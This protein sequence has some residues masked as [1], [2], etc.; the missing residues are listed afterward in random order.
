MSPLVS[1]LLLTYNHKKYISQAIESVL[2]QK[3][4][5]EFEILIGDDCS[6]DGTCEIVDDYQK[7]HPDFIKTIRSGENVGALKNE[8]RL[9]EAAE[10]KYLA[11]LE[12]DDYWTDSLKLQ[13]QIEFLEANPDYGLVHGDVNHYYENTGKMEYAV[14][15][16]T[17]NKIP[18]GNIFNELIKPNP[19]FIKTATACF[20]KELF[21]KH[22]DYN[23]AISQNWPLTD[24]GIW[25]DIA[26]HSKVYYFD[27]VFATYRLLNESASRTSSPSKKLE[28]HQRLF[29]LKQHYLNKY[30]CDAHSKLELEIDYY[31]SLI[32]IAYNLN[33]QEISEQAENY[34][35]S[36][37]I[38]L[39]IKEKVLLLALKK[40]GIMKAIK[41]FKK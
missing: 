31:K 30:R 23:L 38:P 5:F 37:K 1:I 12:G 8:K 40:K 36:K 10:G 34:L 13:K 18:N 3:T 25:M 22:F 32:K 29:K 20:R 9:M 21:Q 17:G 26:F 6:T 24:L 35:K 7:K 14:N 41:T 11:F 33:N 4:N 28:F 15:K 39:G 16:N 2:N 27:E 19:L